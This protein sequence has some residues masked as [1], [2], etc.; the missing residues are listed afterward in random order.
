MT[1]KLIVSSTLAVSALLAQST[2]QAAV[3]INDTFS[4]VGDVRAGLYMLDRDDRD[5]SA[6]GKR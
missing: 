6:F 1:P 4:L 3:P 2:L 5:G